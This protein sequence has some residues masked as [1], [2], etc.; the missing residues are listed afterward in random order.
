MPALKIGHISPTEAEDAAI[1]AGIAADPDAFEWTDE[2]FAQAKAT[3][4]RPTVEHPKKVI[5]M[6]LD[7]D[8]VAALRASG[9]GWQTR[10]NQLLR[11]YV[12]Q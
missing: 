10:V 3:R 12:S 9:K 8:V 11:E 5:S 1:N 7:D 6:R 2:M 4:G